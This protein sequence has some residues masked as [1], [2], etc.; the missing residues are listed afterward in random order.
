[1]GSELLNKKMAVLFQG[2]DVDKNGFVDREDFDQITANFARIRG[3]EP[4]S[5]DY[6]NLHNQLISMWEDYWINADIDKDN[7][8]SLDEWIESYSQQY[9]VDQGSSAAAWQKP[10][11]TLFE[12]IDID[13]D[14]KI[15]V[16]EYKQLLTA[17]GFNASGYEEIFQKLDTNGDGY[18]FKQEYLQLIK[19]F[20]GENPEATG[21][22][23]YGYY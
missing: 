23:F 5:S 3:W 9:A 22:L 14:E 11:A 20:C 16:E 21:N 8:V 18:I 13:G 12:V 17:F 10:M 4:G 7:K 2:L 6:E 1:M 15:A 19:E